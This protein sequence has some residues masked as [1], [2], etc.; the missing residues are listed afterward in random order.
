M[1]KTILMGIVTAIA[2][3]MTVPPT[4]GSFNMPS[5]Y[6]DANCDEAGGG[7]N[8]GGNAKGNAKQCSQPDAEGSKE[9]VRNCDSPNRFKDNDGDDNK[10][11]KIRGSN[12]D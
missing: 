9:P 2:M 1:E 8:N 6:A 4:I 12:S 11:C 7:I 5:A 3:L 10:F